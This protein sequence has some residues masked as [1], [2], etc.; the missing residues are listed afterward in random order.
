MTLIKNIFYDE[1]LFKK[2]KYCFLIYL[3][4]CVFFRNIGIYSVLKIDSIVFACLGI[5]GTILTM[6]GILSQNIIVNYKKEYTYD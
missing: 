1:F 6:W 4:I 5:C 3:L 2:I